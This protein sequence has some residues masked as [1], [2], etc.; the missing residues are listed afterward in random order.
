MV[1]TYGEA[2]VDLI[3]QLDGSFAAILGGSVCNFTL[4]VAR[5]GLPAAYLNPLSNDSFGARFVDQLGAA[6][7]V[8]AAPQRSLL[9]TALAVVTLDAHGVPSYAFHRA[10]VADRDITL[11]QAVATLPPAITLFHTGGLALVPADLD[12]T[13][14][15]AAAAAAAGAL[16]SID[17][18]L[19]PL[20]VPDLALYAA[21]VR[22]ALA[23][24]H[25]IKVSEE[26]LL[27]LG[28][29]DADPVVAARTLFDG[30]AAQLVALTLGGQ[31]AVLLARSGQVALPVPPGVSVVDTVG[32]GDCFQ[33]GLVA[34]LHQ[35]GALTLDALPGLDPGTLTR[36]LRYALA[37]ASIDVM[38]KGCNP[39]LREEVEDFLTTTG[40][41]A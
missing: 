15:V 7:V 13:L 31:G 5:Q 18:N 28:L 9:P 16:I 20:A 34:S 12:V 23:L 8:L 2:L 22:R 3:E 10:L 11:A 4:A 6:G 35:A 21:G 33:A 17:A 19:R 1:V 40:A 27:Y 30:S 41:A 29:Q 38:R 36:A 37:T 26:D 24:A 14:G 32:A 25:L 39:P